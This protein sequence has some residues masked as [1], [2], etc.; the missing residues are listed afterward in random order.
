MSTANADNA[1]IDTVKGKDPTVLAQAR[2]ILEANIY[3]TLSTCS[4]DGWPWASP[5]FFTYDSAWHLYWSSAIAARHSQNLAQNQGRSMIAIYSTHRGEGKGQGLY[6]SGVAGEL[7]ADRVDA[8]M[9]ALFRRA[10]GE[11]PQRTATDY[12]APSPRR[13][14]AFRPERVWI[15]GERL[16]VGNQLVD[17]KIELSLADVL[18]KG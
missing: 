8:V 18:A 9:Q 1:W 3:G 11:P 16:A 13:I 4:A 7:D 5:V 12:L 14:Y 15:T 17:T 2:H 10:G 6:L